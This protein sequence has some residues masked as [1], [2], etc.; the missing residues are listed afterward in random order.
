M[1]PDIARLFFFFFEDAADERKRS[2]EQRVV[3]VSSQGE[4]CWRTRR[5]TSKKKK[6]EPGR[7]RKKTLVFGTNLK[8]LLRF[9]KIITGSSVAVMVPPHQA[10]LL[11]V[12][13]Q[14]PGAVVHDICKQTTQ[15]AYSCVQTGTG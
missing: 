1:T 5:K 2:L 9:G 10:A 7:G 11:A 13:E 4:A 8:L 12:E 6:K 15:L 14:E 3:M